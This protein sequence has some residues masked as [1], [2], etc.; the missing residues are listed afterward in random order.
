MGS[1]RGRAH[2]SYR[3]GFSTCPAF[4]RLSATG[5]PIPPL[6]PLRGWARADGNVDRAHGG[7]HHD[8]IPPHPRGWTAHLTGVR[9]AH[10]TSLPILPLALCSG[11]P[12][13]TTGGAMTDVRATPCAGSVDAMTDV[14]ATLRGRPMPPQ[15]GYLPPPRRPHHRG[16]PL[17]FSF[18][19]G[20]HPWTVRCSKSCQVVNLTSQNSQN[21]VEDARDYR[22]CR[23]RFGT[24]LR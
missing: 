12:D 11:C 7:R 17:C 14:G 8:R 16:Y 21:R 9:P 1:W 18:F 6:S 20:V 23:V 4:E 2:E 19:R 3:R 15:P 22:Q 10:K 5:T 24:A 13:A